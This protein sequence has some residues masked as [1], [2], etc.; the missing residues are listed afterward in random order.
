MDPQNQAEFEQFLQT[1]WD[2]H[3]DEQTQQQTAIPPGKKTGVLRYYMPRIAAV[4]AALIAV[5]FS[6]H[7]FTKPGKHIDPKPTIAAVNVEP[8]QLPARSSAET[9]SVVPKAVEVKKTK[10]KQYG[11]KDLHTKAVE[12]APVEVKQD[13]TTKPQAPARSMK[14]TAINKVM[15]NDSALSKLSPEDRLKVL[16]KLA[17]SVNF[18][19]ANFREVAI[20]LRD[21][22][23]IVL[24]LCAGTSPDKVLKEYTGNY[25]NIAFPDL[26][27]DMSSQMSFSYS[28][29]SNVVKV[30]FN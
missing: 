28:V 27:K 6:V 1:Y 3:V 10:T 25:S 8:E 7:Y 5:V 21:K 18:N 23:G 19:N 29:S 14:M 22:Y 16:N 13:T 20:A 4:A 9:L 24:E 26:I 15:L 17:L 30:C 12:P 2:E 11:K